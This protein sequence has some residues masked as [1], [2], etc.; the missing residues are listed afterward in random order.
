MKIGAVVLNYRDASL[1]SVCLRSL[2]GQG[3]GVA[4]VVDNSDDVHASADLVVVMQ[5]LR[6]DGAD[7]DIRV[8]TPPENIGFAR[9]VNM[10]LGCDVA[11]TCEL[12][13]LLNNDAVAAPGMVQ[14]LLR[15]MA[16]THVGIAVPVIQAAEGVPRPGL[17]YQ[18]Y[19]G[20]MTTHAL[21]GAFPFPSGCC[22]MVGR[23]AL[24][25]GK[26]FDEDFFMYGEDVLLGWR[27]WQA[28]ETPC[29]VSGAV[30]YHGGSA[31]AGNRGLFHEYH[32]A[33]GHVLLARKTWRMRP[34]I[35]LMLATKGT[36]M[37][38]RAAWRALRQR[39]TAPLRAFLLAWFSMEIRPC[40]D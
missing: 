14:A 24:A 34:E 16:E 38:L 13:L 3:V 20:L 11:Q 40:H 21:P 26:L 28:G 37:L 35:P 23:V 33:R 25:D 15:A 9:G 12:F 19:S 10:A 30:A 29:V 32:T 4:L 6:D 18:R 27:R 8:L 39:D 31:S 22:L 17:W 2:V 5:R 7:F 36:V 1:T